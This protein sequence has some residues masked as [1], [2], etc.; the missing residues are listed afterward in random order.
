MGVFY[1]QNLPTV[2]RVS[3]TSTSYVTVYIALLL[4]QKPA[5]YLVKE[6]E[7]FIPST[8]RRPYILLILL[9]DITG[10]ILS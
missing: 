6:A 10:L 5:R 2:R 7:P 8:V 1:S 3:C 4:K 9:V